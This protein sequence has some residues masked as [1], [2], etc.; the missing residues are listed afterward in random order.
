MTSDSVISWLM[1]SDWFL[2]SSW[3]VLLV[4]A[5]GLAFRDWPASAAEPGV[6][7]QDLP[8]SAPLAPR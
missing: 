5:V 4:T 8:P 7:P 2:L 6:R 3:I 1:H